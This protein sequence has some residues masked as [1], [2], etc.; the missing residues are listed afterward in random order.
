[1]SSLQDKVIAV[2]GAASGLGLAFANL[3][4]SRGAKLALADNQAEA[5]EKVA[6]DQKFMGILLIKYERLFKIYVPEAAMSLGQP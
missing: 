2:T 6:H 3:A 1:M 4:V 5:L